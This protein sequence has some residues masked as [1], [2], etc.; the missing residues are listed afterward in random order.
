MGV[1]EKLKQPILPAWTE[2]LVDGGLYRILSCGFE[3]YK[4]DIIEK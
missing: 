3:I 2:S 4:K 1:E